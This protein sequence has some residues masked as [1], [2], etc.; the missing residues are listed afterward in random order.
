MNSENRLHRFSPRYIFKELR[1][2][3][4]FNTVAIYIVGA[5]VVLQAADLAF[6]GLGI[7]ESA[8]RFV[9]I[10]AFLLVP[11]VLVL[12]WRYDISTSG[13]TRTPTVGAMSSRRLGEE[14]RGED[15]APT[16][17]DT[18]LQR[19]D[20][21]L[22]GSMGTIAVAVIAIMLVQIQ[23]AEMDPTYGVTPNSIAV[24][25]F[26][27][28]GGDPGD[29]AQAGGIH[30]AVIDHLAA[31]KRLKV[32][33]RG[34]VY[35]MAGTGM[36]LDQVADLFHVQYLLNGELCRDGVDLM[37]KAELTDNEQLIVWSGSFRQ[38]V[39]RFDQVDQQLATL[40]AN[41]VAMELGEMVA[42]GYGAPVNALALEKLRIGQYHRMQGDDDNAR[43]AF[44]EALEHEPDFAEAVFELA[45][46][47]GIAD[48][49]VVGGIREALPIAERALGLA[50]TEVERGVND[51]KPH[52]VIAQI[53]IALSR[54]EEGLTWRTSAD[55]SEAEVIANKATSRE[56]LE[57]AEQH[58]R[59]AIRLNPSESDLRKGL[60]HTL[61]RIGGQR[62]GEALEIL[63]QGRI[64]EPF[65]E[66]FT[67]MLAHRL[68]LRGQY[69]RAMEEIER[70]KLLGEVPHWLRL[71]QLEIQNDYG[72][73]DDKMELLVD[74]L[75][76]ETDKVS[77]WVLAHLYWTTS[78]IVA[79]GLQQE[80]ETLYQKVSAIPD[81]Y[82]DGDWRRQFFLH[83]TYR[84]VTGKGE[85]VAWEKLVEVEG[86]SNEEILDRWYLDAQ[87]FAG[88][89]WDIGEFERAI[90]LYE[91]LRHFSI[92]PSWAQR[93]SM[94]K[95]SLVNMYMETGR[96]ADAEPVLDEV[97]S[98]LEQE[99]AAGTRHPFTLGELAA[100]YA[101][102]GQDE[103]ALDMLKMAVDYGY[104]YLIGRDAWYQGRRRA[105]EWHALRDDKRFERQLQRMQAMADQQADTIRSLLATYDMDALLV[106]VIEMEEAARLA[107]QENPSP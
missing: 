16:A 53:L 6:P 88:S 91:A 58:L 83:D 48:D 10:A 32:I 73:Y 46:V 68:A 20:H 71:W 41:G 15:A 90:E 95:M 57:E 27:W 11:L 97:I 102:Q 76:H 75:Q 33:G 2:R 50:R 14:H 100:A 35:N 89:F 49:S 74:L 85:E 40:V 107:K 24:M 67:R 77:G 18:S 23:R 17:P 92:S 78:E 61:D 22:I 59:A 55:L 29:V 82:G 5:W 70:F 87:I 31:R 13:I 39:N 7:P 38:V 34:S 96:P 26:E 1:R 3:R 72:R 21:W 12:G 19:P 94:W 45:L 99:V 66:E 103:A 51:Y 30:A 36:A 65:D 25:P 28:C 105:D 42:T 98:L 69:R 63:E 52:W 86:M 47:T 84:N 60:V 56:M 101:W 62:R 104:W 8:I 64:A 4:V 37:L 54:W 43:T 93:S 81:Q 80:A 106:P 9:W 44:E 79:L